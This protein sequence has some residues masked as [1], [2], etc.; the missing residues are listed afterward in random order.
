MEVLK[1][2]VAQLCPTVWDPMDYRVHGI[3]LARALEC[4]AFPFSRGSS[5][6]RSLN[7]GRPGIEPRSPTFQA[8]SL[9]AK[10]PGK[11][12]NTGVGSLSFSSGSSQPRYR[13]GVSCISGGFFTSWAT[14]E[15]PTLPLLISISFR[16]AKSFTVYIHYDSQSQELGE[17]TRHRVSCFNSRRRSGSDAPQAHVW[18]LRVSAF[19][20]FEP[21]VLHS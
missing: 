17:T 3:L 19:V 7:P 5:W 1:M 11:P 20:S 21:W 12:K 18:S 8:D 6:P 2:K 13:T 4:I 9:P 15:A 14:R 10:P 16:F